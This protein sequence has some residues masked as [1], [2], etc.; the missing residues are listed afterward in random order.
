MVKKVA[1]RAAFD[2]ELRNAGDRAV[3]VDFY[4]TWCGP[5]Q[6][7]APTVTEL[8]Q[9]YPSVVVLKVD[10]D[11]AEDIAEQYNINSMP[12]FKV[13]I[14]GSPVQGGSL[15]GASASRLENLFKKYQ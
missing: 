3:I 2:R 6:D 10:V 15:A 1:T 13:F 14:N 4:A 8:S 9:R 7:I 11:E 5:C 12:T